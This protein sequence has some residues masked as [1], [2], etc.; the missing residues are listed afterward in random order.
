MQV[1]VCFLF[2]ILYEL[3]IWIFKL[4]MEENTV[5]P[6]D[7]MGLVSVFEVSVKRI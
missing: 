3:R 6:I 4:R 5:V 2:Q 1:I 7:F